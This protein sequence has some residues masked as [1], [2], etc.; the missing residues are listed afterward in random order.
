MPRISE[1]KPTQESDHKGDVSSDYKLS[2][3]PGMPRDDSL[4]EKALNKPSRLENRN[5]LLRLLCCA[6]CLPSWAAVLVWF[7]IMSLAIAFAVIGI[8]LHTATPPKFSIADVVPVTDMAA[9]TYTNDSFTIHFNLVIN[10]KNPNIFPIHFSH[11]NATAYYPMPGKPV[12]GSSFVENEYVPIKSDYN[13]SIPFS[14]T[15]RPEID[16]YRVILGTITSHC[17]VTGGPMKDITVTYSINST[18]NALLLVAHPSFQATSTL[19]CPIQ[20]QD[21]PELAAITERFKL[22]PSSNVTHTT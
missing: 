19:P 13:K 20:L 16:R 8:I 4:S 9:L 17:G 1:S 15:Y 5:R 14:M 21:V 10:I 12:A 2:L 7:I 18:A 6:D 3:M 11:V 22:K